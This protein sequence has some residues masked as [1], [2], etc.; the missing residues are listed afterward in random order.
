M[1]VANS[2]S[3][4]YKY[5]TSSRTSTQQHPT[6]LLVILL[7]FS[8]VDTL[9]VVVVLHDLSSASLPPSNMRPPSTVAASP[10]TTASTS[11]ASLSSSAFLGSAVCSAYTF[12]MAPPP[13][14]FSDVSAD[15]AI[16]RAILAPRIL[17]AGA[18]ALRPYIQQQQQHRA[19]PPAPAM[20]NPSV[21]HP[22]FFTENLQRRRS[23]GQPAA[24]VSAPPA[25]APRHVH[26]PH[27]AP[28]APIAP[29]QARPAAFAPLAPPAPPLPHASSPVAH[30]Y[31]YRENVGWPI[32]Q[33]AR[34]VG[35]GTGSKL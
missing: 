9:S 28:F 16:P 18:H 1:A 35:I 19:P 11:S 24:Q 30:G 6:S 3:T 8:T 17:P 5:Y 27:F 15:Y 32:Q 26:N 12:P 33:R 14:S 34:P 13:S 29:Y 20:H 7:A 10:S 21:L 4:P 23:F 22:V 2:Q 31:I 25:A